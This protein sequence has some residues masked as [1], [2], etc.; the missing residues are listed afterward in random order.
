MLLRTFTA[1]LALLI[2]GA[3]VWAITADSDDAGSAQRATSPQEKKAV[4]VENRL[5][6]D[7]S[8]E[9]LLLATM[10]AWIDAGAD[11]LFEI[12]TH[13]E[14]IPDAVSEDYEAGLQAWNDYLRQ[15]AGKADVRLAERVGATFFQLVEIG[16]TSPREVTANAAG[17]VR[18]QRI[19]CK[20]EPNMYTLSDLATYEYFN[21]E[22]ATGDRTARQAKTSF[23]AEGGQNA[24]IV[25]EQLYAYRERGEKFVARVKKGFETLKE[26]G[27]EELE[28]PI[29]G[30]GSAAGINGYEPGMG[31]NGPISES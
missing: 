17:A 9:G 30:Y 3:L 4:E 20:H 27:E 15:T 5:A 10:N 11:R 1:G 26:T 24:G 12:E 7:P 22:I 16:S 25:L 14:P 21:G 13:T 18:A 6:K 29:K 23:V 28:T 19:V 31:P 2:G 8:N